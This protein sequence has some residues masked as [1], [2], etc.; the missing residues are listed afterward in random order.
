MTSFK[1]HY[2][3]QT[4]TESIKFQSIYEIAE[5]LNTH[6]RHKNAGMASYSTPDDE[7]GGFSFTQAI[8]LA[9]TGGH[10]QQGANDLNKIELPQSNQHHV[11]SRRKLRRSVAG[12]MPNVP[13]YL[14]NNP[15][16]MMDKKRV[17]TPKKIIKVGVHVGRV[18]NTEQK[19]VLNRGRAI[20]ST[21]EALQ[22]QGYSVEVWAVWRNTCSRSGISAHIDTLIKPS[23]APWQA[24]LAAFTL[25]NLAFQR[26]LCWG[27]METMVHGH[28]LSKKNY[29]NGRTADMSD[30]DLSYGY[31]EEQHLWRL[32]P[33]IT[34]LE[35]IQE[36]TNDQLNQ[37]N[38]M[39]A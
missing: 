33:P 4:K 29:G 26:R 30:F 21:I 27:V 3:K 14:S 19:H 13:A 16:N 11:A 18:Y 15:E 35:Y 8:D 39:V 22:L 5:Y 32:D 34:A 23:T 9:R 28:K 36:L 37:L 38:N 10:W 20:M 12:F 17:N 7:C 31:V 25:A 6:D 24:S 1:T 2:D